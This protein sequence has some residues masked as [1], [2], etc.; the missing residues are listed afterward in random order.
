VS[1]TSQLAARLEDVNP[2]TGDETLVARGLYRPEVNS[3]VNPTRQVFQLH[4][5]GWKFEQGHVAKLELLPADQPYG[6]NSNGQGLLIVSN[7]ELRLPVLEEPGSLN[8]LVQA[9][10]PKVVPPG[11]ELVNDTQTGYPRPK[12]ASP[13]RVSLTPAYQACA[14]PNDQHGAPLAF[15]S[16]NPPNPASS[17]LTVGTGDSNGAAA[18]STGFVLY[19][20]TAG[21]VNVTASMTDVREQGTLAD[22]T[23]ELS[24]EQQVQ[25]TDSETESTTTQSNPVR[26][27]VPCAATGSTTIGGT[28]SLSS[29]FNAIIPGAVTAGNRAIWELGDIRVFDGGPDDQAA[30]TAGNTLFARQG[31]FVP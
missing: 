17:F 14:S 26:F 29:S 16:C 22:Y 31:L 8:G 3:G 9:P 27:G 13:F 19:K 25:L 5:N 23:G 28:C 7:L 24:V 20:V 10:A 2:S 6:R 1:P 30:T 12:G 15:N 18:N 4:P 11:Y 21:D